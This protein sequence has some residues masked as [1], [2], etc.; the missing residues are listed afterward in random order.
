MIKELIFSFVSET[1]K[2]VFIRVSAG[3][4]H[5]LHKSFNIDHGKVVV[6]FGV[7]FL[8]TGVVAA[9]VAVRW[10]WRMSCMTLGRYVFITALF[11]K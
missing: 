9:A 2:H 11:E 3:I 10:R 1:P 5:L 8:K 4:N 6:N 7:F